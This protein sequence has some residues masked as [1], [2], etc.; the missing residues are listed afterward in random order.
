[1]GQFGTS[2]TATMQNWTGF[3]PYQ[4][5]RITTKA[6]SWIHE[7]RRF[8]NLVKLGIHFH[9]TD[10]GDWTLE[11]KV[12]IVGSDQFLEEPKLCLL[13]LNSTKEI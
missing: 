12:Q 13:V 2:F 5:F 7:Q 6:G 1:M 11:K 8:P 3:E 10:L 4:Y 9:W